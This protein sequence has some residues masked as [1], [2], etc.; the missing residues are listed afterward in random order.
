VRVSQKDPKTI[1]VTSSNPTA[2]F[3]PMVY[4]SSDS[5][6]TFTSQPLANN[7]DGVAPYSIELLATD[8][9]NAAVVWGRALA[10]IPTATDSVIRHALLR[11]AD[12]GKTFVELAKLD[13]F[14]EP[15]GQ[16]RGIDDVAFD[17]QAKLVY[18]A[19]RTGLLSGSDDGSTTTPSLA[20][21]PSLHQS[22]CADVHG[23][24]LYACSS[25][26]PP[27]N[28]A[29]ARSMDNGKTFS[30]VLNYVDTVGPVDYCP[31]GTPVGDNCPYYWYTYASYLG[32]DFDG[33]TGD[34]SGMPQKSHG[35]CGCDLGA[36]AGVGA[37]ALAGTLAALALL[38]V[39][40]RTGAKNGGRARR[41]D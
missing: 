10:V 39:A 1:Y 27:D 19:T 38:F 24:A 28:A 2:P 9:R 13:A 7:V 8:P 32:I 22:Q 26:Y 15:S 31:A 25:Q 35:G 33:G 16:T 17:T 6:K 34:M 37:G 12:G 4:A 23:G 14:T 18:A 36:R 40:I 21:L 20:S 11:S 30:S 5:G 29:V 41:R 3:N